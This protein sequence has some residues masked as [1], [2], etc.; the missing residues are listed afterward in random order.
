[1][2]H[3]AKEQHWESRE[4]ALLAVGKNGPFLSVK[5]SNVTWNL[6]VESRQKTHGP[7]LS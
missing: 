2:V 7:K 3:Q 4:T 1:M 6:C 5:I